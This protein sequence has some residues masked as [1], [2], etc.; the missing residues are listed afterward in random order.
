MRTLDL[1][2]ALSDS[3]IKEVEKLLSGGKREIL[4]KVFKELK[5]YATKA[6]EPSHEE[7]F[8]KLMKEPYAKDKD[9]LLR[10]RMRQLNEIL[11]EYLATDAFKHTC[12]RNPDVFNLWLTKAY[13]D[14][15]MKP[16]FENE[17]DGALESAISHI[18]ARSGDFGVD[19]LLLYALKS[20]WMI[21]NE[22]RIPE[23][24]EKQIAFSDKWMEEL[25]RRFLYKIREIEARKA[26]LQMMHKMTRNEPKADIPHRWGP[27]HYGSQADRRGGLV[28]Q[29]SATKKTSLPDPRQGDDQSAG[30]DAIYQ[31]RGGIR[32]HTGPQ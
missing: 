21:N 15:K 3:E 28:R 14:R 11:Y 10:N 31:R 17:I 24:I 6:D 7:L 2:K 9:Y 27:G 1:I 4:L 25:K 19:S 8:E 16:L 30:G 20:L 26:F 29:V 22:P 12:E 32:C 18:S 23:N 13:Y 5:K